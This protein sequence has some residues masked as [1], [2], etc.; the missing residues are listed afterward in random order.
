MVPSV[1]VYINL[2][3]S[4]CHFPEIGQNLWF[5]SVLSTVVDLFPLVQLIVVSVGFGV[6]GR[7]EE[8]IDTCTEFITLCVKNIFNNLR[9]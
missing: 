6:G 7:G 8:T 4:S 9:I 1:L 5:S 2:I 3:P